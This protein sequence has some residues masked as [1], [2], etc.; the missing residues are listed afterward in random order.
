MLRGESVDPVIIDYGLATH[1]DL[2][3]YLFFRCGTPGY[4]APEII[5]L[6]HS[7][8]TEPVCDIFSLGAIFHLLLARKPLFPGTKFDEVYQKNRDLEMD[9][10]GPQLSGI[11][12]NA[13]SLLKAMLEV[14]PAKRITAT[15][16]LQHSY[17]S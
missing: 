15:Q 2:E 7:Q 1:S 17:F 4:V 10:D 16:A 6:T 14:N 9:L 11:S 3:N 5:A 13:K 8:H 12:P